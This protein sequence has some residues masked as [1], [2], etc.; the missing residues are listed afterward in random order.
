[1]KI[2]KTLISISILTIYLFFTVITIAF[3]EGT[4]TKQNILGNTKNV[5]E[6]AGYLSANAD[7]LTA[8]IA[9]TVKILLSFLG[10][11]FLLLVIISG[12]QW[13]TAGG[14]EDAVKKARTKIKNA[15]IG[16]IIIVLSYSLTAFIEFEIIKK[17][18]GL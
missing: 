5:S 4:S 13:M 6:N 14:N 8:T 3:A 18:Q 15:T 10:I 2:K 11:I 12:F 1:M 9:N 16:L 17:A 7:T